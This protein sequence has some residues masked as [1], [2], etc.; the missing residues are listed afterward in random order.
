MVSIPLISLSSILAW[1]SVQSS[2]I[3][4]IGVRLLDKLSFWI[5][6]SIAT[7]WLLTIDLMELIKF[8]SSEAIVRDLI[9]LCEENSFSRHKPSDYSFDVSNSFKG[10]VKY[11]FI[12]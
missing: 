10:W 1:G 11:Y 12:H 4:N 5:I 8:L 6:F 9:Q 2:V 3:K 7:L